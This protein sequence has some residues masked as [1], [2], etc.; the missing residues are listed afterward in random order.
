[1]QGNTKEVPN[2][3]NRYHMSSKPCD[4][5]VGFGGQGQDMNW[6]QDYGQNVC[7]DQ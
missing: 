2:E 4:V 7:K 1:M 5:G 3:W 6:T